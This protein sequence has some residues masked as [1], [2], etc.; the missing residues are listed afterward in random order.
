MKPPMEPARESPGK[1]GAANSRPDTHSPSMAVTAM[2]YPR[3]LNL[4]I[5]V[6][7]RI[8]QQGGD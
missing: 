3:L 6:L 7:L 2:V 8:R 1:G 5:A 4:L